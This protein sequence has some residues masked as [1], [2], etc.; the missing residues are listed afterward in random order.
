MAYNSAVVQ[1]RNL[2][3]SDPSGFSA[4]LVVG[5]KILGLALGVVGLIGSLRPR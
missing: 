4:S 3:A 5:I 2:N 1:L